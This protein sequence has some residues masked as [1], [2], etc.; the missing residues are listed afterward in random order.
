MK[1]KL[2][3]KEFQKFSCILLIALML[4]LTLS[5]AF[6]E[7]L[8]STITAEGDA[9]PVGTDV[10]I[11][12]V[13]DNPIDV[14][15][16]CFSP[17]NERY[18]GENTLLPNEVA[19][20]KRKT[21][22]ENPG[23]S[24]DNI[25]SGRGQNEDR[26]LLKN[27]VIV[28]E[29]VDGEAI[30]NE[31]PAGKMDIGEISP[32][33][34][35]WFSGPFAF[36]ISLDDTIRL[37]QCRD[38]PRLVAEE[39]GCPILGK[40]LSYR[41][42]G[43]G[44]VNNVKT[45]WDDFADWITPDGIFEGTG[46]YTEEQLENVQMNI[47]SNT[48]P[49]T[50][51][52]KYIQKEVKQIPNSV[53]AEE[54]EASM[55]TAGNSSESLI[56]IYSMFDKYYNS[57]F[58]TEMVVSVFG[59]TL[60]GTAKKYAGWLK[61]R[62]LAFD[63]TDSKIMQWFRRTFYEP[64]GVLG[65]ARL[66]RMV[67]R[68]DRYGFGDA[69]TKGIEA[70]GDWDSGYAFIKGGSFRKSINDWSKPGG[71]LEEMTDPIQRGEFFKQISDLRAYAHTNKAIW[72]QKADAYKAALNAAG[73]AGASSPQAKAALMDWAQTNADL[74]L[75]ADGKILR[76]DATELW[77]KE[78]VTGLYTNALK[79]K[80]TGGF[81]SIV[82][83]SK[84]P[85]K[86]QQGFINTVTGESGAWGD[87]AFEFATQGKMLE[88]Y[89]VDK[90]GE[91]LDTVPVEDLQKGFSRYVKK[92]AMTEKGELIEINESTIP[93]IM[94]ESPTG[95]VDIYTSNWKLDHLETP[96]MYAKRLVDLRSDRIMNTMSIN[97]DRLYNTLIE[98]NFAGQSRRYYSVLDK[99]FAQE[100]E[101][102]KS[103]LGS[104]KGALEWTLKPYLYWGGKRAF[105]FEGLSAFM[106]PDE[107]IEVEL[108]TEDET[109]F[110][111]A[112]IDVFAQHGS[113]EGE[114]FIQ[115]LNKL[116]WKAVLNYATEKIA[117][118]SIDKAYD[119]WTSPSGGWRRGVENVAY[120][121]ST[122]DDCATCGVTLVP[123]VLSQEEL[124]NLE[125]KGRG[126]AVIAFNVE[127][128][129]KSY[130]VEDII[131]DDVA[132]DGTTLI[133]F[134]HHTNISGESMDQVGQEASDID[135]VKARKDGETCAD[136]VKDMG[137]GFLGD[138]PQRIG[139]LLA[140][141]ESAGYFLFIGVGLVGSA[142]QQ[143][144]LAPKL[145]D[146]VDD[147]EGYYLH[148]YS[149][150]DSSKEGQK[151]P[152]ANAS[153]NAI[154]IIQNIDDLV[155]GSPVQERDDDDDD[156][157]PPV[158]NK[159]QPYTSTSISEED[160]D[161]RPIYERIWNQDETEGKSVVEL[162]KEK[163]INTSEMLSQKT[164]SAA[165]LQ[166]DFETKGETHG[167]AFFE[168]MFFF[169]FKGNTQPAVYDNHS[170][171]ILEDDDKDVAVIV[172]KKD[173]SISVKQEGK[174]A[175]KVISSEDHVRMSGP[176]GRVPAE[177]IPQRIGRVVLPTGPAIELFEM[178]WQGN[179]KVL[180]QRILDCIRQN[181]LEQTGVPLTTLDITE[182]FGRAEAI[183]TDRYPS[184]TT[185]KSEKSIIA[186]G[187]PREIVY[188]PSARVVVMT[189]M[190]T[191]LLNGRAI[192][193]G[194][195]VSVQFKNGVILYKPASGGNPAELLIWLRYHERSILR[196]SQVNG[197]KA[198]LD[199][200]INAETGCPEPAINLEAIPNLDAG[201]RSQT[202]ERVTNFNT[203]IEKMGP[204]QIFDT[205]RHRFVFYS[206]KT[207]NTCNVQDE[208]C[209][210]DRVSIIDKQTGEIYD[211]AIVGDIEQT[212]EGIEFKT[213]DGKNHTLDFSADNGVPKITYNDMA[214]ETLTMARGP[215]GAFWYDPETELWSP[216]N[217][218]LL[219]LLEA[220]KTSGFD[221][222]HRE[223]CSSSTLPGGNT[224]NV[225][226]GGSAETPFNLPSLPSA[227]LEML[228]FILTL[229][230]VICVA[231]IGIEKR[232]KR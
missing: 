4:N 209:C 147:I 45:V 31:L 84:P 172:D 131:D 126:R 130:F 87:D 100:Q 19:K 107:W 160:A 116:P 55:K 89:K 113:D 102:I 158:D 144:L 122:R 73:D 22:V 72:Q 197:L 119:Q 200:V 104:V 47:S 21:E 218:Q 129:M 121:T 137:L 14:E 86:M 15:F 39:R 5:P 118:S 183:V 70:T 25:N 231:R 181:V 211:Q 171:S 179:F 185:S 13:I 74:M 27:D 155:R 96:E 169:W 112:Y 63:T 190:N 52:A 208:G 93:Y 184:I 35:K 191:T 75:K 161:D 83:D 6:G 159:G 114:I 149:P 166:I 60:V 82:G 50:L 59:P 3:K 168:K 111:D 175:E 48:D 203:A 71:Y 77:V 198:I 42:S 201:D 157:G 38:L 224:M 34:N 156:D 91:L 217:A 196:P 152:N 125:D 65:E 189:D 85:A 109:I 20:L 193:V 228:L 58:S 150:Y 140:V 33:F 136:V 180:D 138:D 162:A 120:F 56:S 124:S 229:M 133:A 99:M 51:Q 68:T 202:T 210:Q 223:D 90:A 225:N 192:P 204:F 18:T 67:T 221:T 7:E 17:E 220:F 8:P 106:L 1:T 216:Y 128:D 2:L 26:E 194:D 145:Q 146:C 28:Q 37:G 69:W 127:Q 213:D 36:G 24:I 32:W 115:V 141:S 117:P 95:K 154:N 94:K 61:R 205:D 195:M 182:A 64:G 151:T 81:V 11:P 110:D 199:Q 78:E 219:P 12:K 44:I 143:T 103:Y 10:G 92:A 174:P 29:T 123:I 177:V 62:G 43:E 214:P 176:D 212:P 173:G 9:L 232:L 187:S 178:D 23:F 66:K 57:W 222:R 167:V 16:A 227:P 76:L 230:A 186:N 142:L 132:E 105:G 53:L 98:K 215:N 135:L 226:V 40:Q 139:A 153:K 164:Q 188:G 170:V 41:N 79:Y 148:V 108:Y 88:I 46:Q 97:M 30:V 54:I 80:N 101:L 49:E 206:E 207:S 165:L 134:A 163:M